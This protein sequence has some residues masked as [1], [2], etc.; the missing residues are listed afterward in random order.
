MYF[1]WF[2]LERERER[3]DLCNL[4]VLLSQCWKF[5]S[6]HIYIYLRKWNKTGDEQGSTWTQAYSCWCYDW[7]IDRSNIHFSNCCCHGFGHSWECLERYWSKEGLSFATC[8]LHL[9]SFI[10][11]LW[12]AACR[13]ADEVTACIC[14]WI[15]PKLFILH[16]NS[17]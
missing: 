4:F 12:A 8:Y 15:P 14:F 1:Y 2:F 3:E 16:E 13:I 6:F 11:P 9:S 5:S 17:I 10:F 7:Q